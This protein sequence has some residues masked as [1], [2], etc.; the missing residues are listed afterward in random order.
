M[1]ENQRAQDGGGHAGHQGGQGPRLSF[2]ATNIQATMARLARQVVG[3]VASQAFEPCGTAG[4]TAMSLGFACADCGRPACNSHGFA[5]LSLKPEILCA[6][7]VAQTLPAG[8]G[9][10]D[11]VRGAKK[12]RRRK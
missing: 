1:P 9:I 12:A 11:A 4:C 8:G 2:D 3:N 10:G 6:S 7:C 5:T